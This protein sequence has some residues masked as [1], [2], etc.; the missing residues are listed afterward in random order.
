MAATASEKIDETSAFKPKFDANGLIVVAT[1]EATTRKL[2]MIAYMNEAALQKTL[3][4]GEGW[5]YSRSRQALWR[6]GET[7]GNIQKVRELR[8]DCDQDALEMVVDQ[9]GPACHTGRTDCF[10]RRIEGAGDSARL[11]FADGDHPKSD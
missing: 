1:T 2:L 5:Y 10:Y 6:K 7:S 4:T 11:I 8:I 3:E 9:T